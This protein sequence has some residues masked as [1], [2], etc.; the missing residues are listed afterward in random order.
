MLPSIAS[1]EIIRMNQRRI[2]NPTAE[3]K[4]FGRVGSAITK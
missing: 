3:S 2:R 4:I 1:K